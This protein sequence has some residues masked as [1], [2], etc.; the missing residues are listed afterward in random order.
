[1]KPLIFHGCNNRIHTNESKM[2]YF[3]SYIIKFCFYFYVNS[4]LVFILN[5]LDQKFCKK[6]DIYV[7]DELFYNKL[8]LQ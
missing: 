6:T 8:T 3:L 1:M 7:F 2:H 4:F 5:S